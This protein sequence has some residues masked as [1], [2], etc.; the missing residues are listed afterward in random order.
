MQEEPINL[1]NKGAYGDLAMKGIRGVLVHQ[2]LQ[3]LKNTKCVINTHSKGC[4]NLSVRIQATSLHKVLPLLLKTLKGM[5]QQI[6]PPKFYHHITAN[7]IQ[8][9]MQCIEHEKH[10]TTQ[11]TLTKEPMP[12]E[13][14]G[15]EHW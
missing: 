14:F 15:E 10:C 12:E 3:Y 9:E 11:N 5:Y 7:N 1:Q 8:S 6:P 4:L 13:N 2:K